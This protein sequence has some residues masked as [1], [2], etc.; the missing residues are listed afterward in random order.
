MEKKTPSFEEMVRMRV[1]LTV[2]GM[3]AVR[4]GG[5]LVYKTVGDELLHMDVYAPPGPQ[6]QRPVVVLIHGG[7]VPRLGARKMGVFVS[8]G[9]LLAAL[10]FVAVAFDH[11]FLAP[12]RLADAACDVADLAQVLR[13]LAHGLQDDIMVVQHPFSGRAANGLLPIGFIKIRVNCV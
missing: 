4:S 13:H 11:R 9:E 7:P 10:G 8:Y 3:D 1:V 2:P 12:E 6:R 5:A